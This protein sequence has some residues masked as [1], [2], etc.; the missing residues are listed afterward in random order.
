MVDYLRSVGADFEEV[1]KALRKLPSSRRGTVLT[2]S[3][4]GDRFDSY[5]L[6]EKLSVEQDGAIWREVPL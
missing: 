6:A 1:R 4:I 3:P 5:S 2:I